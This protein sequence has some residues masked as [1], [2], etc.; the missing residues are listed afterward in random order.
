MSYAATL[1][2]VEDHFDRTAHEAWVRLTSD[3]PVSRIRATVRAGRDAM[4]AKLIAAL[5]GDLHGARVLDAGCGAG[6]LTA[7]LAAR[8]ATVVAA[9]ISPQLLE[10]AAARLPAAHAGRVRFVAGDMLDPALGR[11]DA[12]VAM[13]SLIYYD[14]GDISRAAADLADRTAGPIVFTVAPRTALLMAMWRIGHLFPRADRAPI[15]VP[16]APAALARHLASETG[17]QIR[18][19]GRVAQGFYISHAMEVRA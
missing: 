16:Q 17:G 10:L 1:A 15:M 14:R 11:F 8:G 19:H 5:P 2:R 6:Q 18:D 9:D 3:A 13:D 4:R 7:E 12:V